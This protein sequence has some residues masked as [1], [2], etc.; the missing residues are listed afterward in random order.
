[1]TVTNKCSKRLLAGV[2][3]AALCAP[4]SYAQGLRSFPASAMSPESARTAAADTAML[5]LSSGAFD[6][7]FSTLRYAGALDAESTTTRIVQ[8]A[9]ENAGSARA[10]LSNA[11]FKILHYYPNNAFVVRLDGK[12]EAQLARIDGVRAVTALK[13]GMKL[14]NGLLFGP[15]PSISPVSQKIELEILAFPGQSAKNLAGALAKLQLGVVSQVIRDDAH[16]PKVRVALSPDRY[17]AFIDAASVLEAVRWIEKY[18]QPYVDNQNAVSPMQANA[19]VGTPIWDRDLIGTGQIVAVMDSGADRNEDWFTSLDTGGGPNSIITDAESP[20]PPAI[21]TL[22]PQAK[23]IGYWVQP[24]SEA[25]DNNNTCPGGNPTSF[26][27][28]HVSGTTVGD[29]GATATPTEPNNGNGDGMAPNAQLLFQDIGNDTS[30][31]LSITDFGGSI[32]QALAANAHLQ[33]NSWGAPTVGAYGGNDIDADAAT[34]VLEDIMVA[35]SAGN[36]GPGPNTTGSPGNS[37]NILTVAALGNGNSTTIAGFSSRGPTDDGR[38]KPDIAGPGTSTTSARGNSN[39]GPAVQAGTTA[40]L[41]G[42]SMSS[43]TVVGASALL[44][45]Y[46]EDG[47][48][49]RG[50]RDGDGSDNVDISGSMTKALLLNGS[51]PLGATWPNND[52]G[53]GRLYLDGSLYFDG[54]DRRVR[55]FERAHAT[56]LATGEEDSY[57]ITVGSGQEFRTTLVWFDIE[58]APGAGVTL[59]NNLNLIVEGPGGTF[60][61]NVL[62]SG[63]SNTGGSADLLNTVE[64]V[65]FTAPTAGSYTL[66]VVGANVPGSSREGSDRQ[67]Y[68][69]VAS[70]VIGL[71]DQAPLAAPASPTIASNDAAGIEVEFSPVGGASGYILYRTNGSCATADLTQL[72]QVQNGAGSQLLD[73]HS[74]GGFEYAYVV[75]AVGNDIEGERSAC[76]DAVSAAPC[77]LQPDF[78]G[79]SFSADSSNSMCSVN[80]NWSAGSTICPAAAAVTYDIFVADEP[81]FTTPVLIGDDVTGTSFADTAAMD[82][83]PRYYQIVA[84]DDFGNSSGSQPQIAATASGRDGFDPSMTVDNVET[85]TYMEA[86]APWTITSARSLSGAF[87]YRNAAGGTGNTYASGTCAYLTTPQFTVP[88]NGEIEFRARFEIEVNWDGVVVEISTDGGA[89]WSAITPVEGYPDTLSMTQDPPINACGFPSTQGAFTG[90]SGGSFDTYTLDLASR[91]GQDVRV[92]WA[93]TSD[94]G[95]EE[96]GFYLDDISFTGN[97]HPVPDRVTLGGFETGESGSGSNYICVSP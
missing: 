34:W 81:N 87:S 56:G 47:F 39:N 7:R 12:Q 89:S 66:R 35:S 63:I 64:Q 52:S 25:Y 60:L 71:P 82:G 77:T 37:K 92:R 22:N 45:Q 58:G 19:A 26:H 74:Q 41:S 51:V 1:M 43:P 62:T 20:V 28:S 9:P 67:G 14:A 61:G 79:N 38:I 5:L 75:R 93:F 30:G 65:R 53:W 16:L 2:I 59:V 97:G 23:V 85:A 31:C 8:F 95:S 84:S 70:G 55:Y 68:S 73:D 24:G 15:T 86:Q 91:T 49:P 88:T 11:G 6:P 42:T 44:R 54:D 13:A 18:E 78:D 33:N 46:F 69:L 94:G 27:G 83:V 50:V 80:L 48:Y 96:E 72:R 4:V 29:R 90:S 36:S 3:L 10:A 57:T 32:A 21:G 17:N 76:V 40:N